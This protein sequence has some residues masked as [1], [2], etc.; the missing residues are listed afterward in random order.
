MEQP[1]S[2]E[3]GEEDGTPHYALVV[4]PDAKFE[5][6]IADVVFLSLQM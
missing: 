1:F 5:S 3:M 6:F 2:V 4:V